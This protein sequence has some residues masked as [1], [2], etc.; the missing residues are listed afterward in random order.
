MESF[1][2]L[3]DQELDF[4]DFYRI[5][6]NGEL[7]LIADDF[8]Q[9]N[10]ICFNPDHTQLFVNDPDNGHIRVFDVAYSTTVTGGSVWAAPEGD[11]P[12]VP[13]GMKMD[14]VGNIFC[15]GPSGV[16]IFAPDATPLGRICMPEVR[17]NFT[18][19]DGDPRSLYLTA[20]NILDRIDTTTAGVD[21]F[22]F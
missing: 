1:G 11:G 10:G 13:E 19:D 8:G 21:L 22:N 16:N 20:T 17:A 18:W 3:R 4:R 7:H 9:P 6:P 12:R 14:A 2:V 15:T 5:V